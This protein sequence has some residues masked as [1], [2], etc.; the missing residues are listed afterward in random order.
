MMK[1]K[2]RDYPMAIKTFTTTLALQT[3]LESACSKAVENACGRLLAVLQEKIDSEFYDKF[4]PNFY[5]RSYQFWESATTKML[6][7]TLG[8]IFMDES[9]MNYSSYWSGEKQLV[10]ANQGI[11]GGWYTTTSLTGHYW[12]SFVEYCEENAMT[13]LKVELIKQGIPVI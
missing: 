10:A 2:K 4:D 5:F 3:Y 8:V 7:K 12:D 11:H 13:I 9:A 1:P 6:E